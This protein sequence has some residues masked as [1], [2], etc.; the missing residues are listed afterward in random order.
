L[1]QYG[2]PQIIGKLRKGQTVYWNKLNFSEGSIPKMVRK[3][4]I[5]QKQ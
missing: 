1:G 5:C 2:K 4:E 3:L